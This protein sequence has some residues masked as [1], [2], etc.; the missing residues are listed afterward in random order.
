MNKRFKSKRK[1]EKL[2]CA[3]PHYPFMGRLQATVR[4]YASVER[5]GDLTPKWFQLFLALWM[6]LVGTHSGCQEPHNLPFHHHAVMLSGDKFN[7]FC[8]A[9]QS[10]SQSNIIKNPTVIFYKKGLDLLSRIK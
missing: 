8:T 10:V 2:P 1:K 4:D 3:F 9:D 5:M 6:Q 7:C